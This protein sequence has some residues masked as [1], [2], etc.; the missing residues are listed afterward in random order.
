LTE[1]Q[2]LLPTLIG[3]LIEAVDQVDVADTKILG[4]LVL[5]YACVF[6]L[7]AQGSEAGVFL[8]LGS[9][10]GHVRGLYLWLSLPSATT[11]KRSQ[12]NS[13]RNVFPYLYDARF[14]VTDV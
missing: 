9:A 1:V 11:R 10:A 7:H 6:L 4:N 14:F 5:G 2:N 13:E 12:N 8:E 3:S